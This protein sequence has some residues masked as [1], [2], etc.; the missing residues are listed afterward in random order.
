MLRVDC[1]ARVRINA[2]HSER[3]QLA[4]QTSTN[5]QPMGALGGGGCRA[6]KLGL[7]IRGHSLWHFVVLPAGSGAEQRVNVAGHSSQ[8]FHAGNGATQDSVAGSHSPSV[9]RSDHARVL[10][11]QQNRA[12][13][14]TGDGAG[15]LR[16]VAR[17]WEV[18]VEKEEP[19]TYPGCATGRPPGFGSPAAGRAPGSAR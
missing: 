4:G 7:H 6:G 1:A 5:V 13:G 15:P 12:P 16:W 17:R 10:I 8:V 18:G 3:E 2:A 11:G 9:N 19:A 14:P